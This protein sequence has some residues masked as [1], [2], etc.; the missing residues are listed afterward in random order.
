MLSF[1]DVNEVKDFVSRNEIEFISFYLSDID[2]R[3]RQVTIPADTF[4]QKTLELGI[5]FD[6]SNFGFAEVDRSDMI[7]KPDLDFAFMDPME[8]DPP[9]LCFFCHMLEVDSKARFTQDLRDLVPKALDVLK[10]EGIAD[11]ARVGVELEFHVLDQL[12]SVRNPREQSFRVETDEMVSPPDGE[13]VYRIAPK[14]GYFRAAPNDHLFAIRNEIVSV[15][16]SL[17]LN[18]K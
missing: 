13:E 9:V 18:K 5:G 10:G 8:E 11:A 7:L 4:S 14:R 2:G 1:A 12:F 17:K 6:A 15:Y 3:L 16:R